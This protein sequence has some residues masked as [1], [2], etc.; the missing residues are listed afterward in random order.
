MHEDNRTVEHAC[1]SQFAGWL[2][3]RQNWI[4]SNW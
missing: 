3:E 2:R 4:T 1:S